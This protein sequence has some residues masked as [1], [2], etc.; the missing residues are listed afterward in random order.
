MNL[1]ISFTPDDANQ[2]LC[3]SFDFIAH[4]PERQEAG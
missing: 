1:R 4:M 2:A 3:L